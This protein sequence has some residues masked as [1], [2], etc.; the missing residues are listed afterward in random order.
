MTKKSKNTVPTWHKSIEALQDSL[1][2]LEYDNDRLREEIARKESVIRKQQLL[3]K[4]A[5]AL[6]APSVPLV[7]TPDPVP[8]EV[9][10]KIGQKFQYL[11]ED[12]ELSRDTML[13]AQVSV[14]E[15]N[16]IGLRSGNRW[17]R[18]LR[19]LCATKI[20]KSAFDAHFE[21]P[22]ASRWVVAV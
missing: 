17:T 13:L 20:P 3:V 10:Y 1:R 18:N 7:S 5:K 4:I 21:G 15:V 14:T 9:F 16:L 11:T 19:V 8:E 2:S 22:C 6:T 12:G